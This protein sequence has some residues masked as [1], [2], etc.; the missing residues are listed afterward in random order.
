ML[1]LRQLRYLDALAANAHFGRAAAALG[2][3]Q[4]ALSVQIR[5]LEKALG[6]PLVHRLP[7]GVRLTAVGSEIASRAAAVLA[8]VREIEEIGHARGR[9]LGSR[10]R[11]GVIP[12]I[13]PYL[14]PGLLVRIG[15]RYPDAA[16]TVR[17]T[18]TRTL[19]E[20]TA[21]G[22]LDALVASVPLGDARFE[23]VPAFKDAFLLAVPAGSVH[24]THSSADPSQIA[25]EEL[26]LLE[27]GHC[28]RDQAL[29]IC[30]AIDPSRLRSFGATSLTTIFHLVAAGQGITLVPEMAADVGVASDPRLKLVRFADPEPYRMVGLAWRRNSPRERD[31][32]ALAELLPADRQ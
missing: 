2:V 31:F 6:A 29:S 11:L 13:A 21:Q 23:E 12:S 32:R 5:E 1:T 19:I 3:T 16:V 26:L 22:E 28:L 27:D 4:P 24:A 7:G 18:V 15:E 25:A 30:R 17:E 9:I 14:L 8:A 20:E 10:L